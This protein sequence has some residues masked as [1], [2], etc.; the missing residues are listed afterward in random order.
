MKKRSTTPPTPARAERW[1]VPY[2]APGSKGGT[3]TVVATSRA[4]AVEKVTDILMRRRPAELRTVTGTKALALTTRERT[5][6]QFG[7]P[8]NLGPVK[9]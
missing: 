3:L 1:Q 5:Q 7:E 2:T 9:P 6:I 4:A 8:V